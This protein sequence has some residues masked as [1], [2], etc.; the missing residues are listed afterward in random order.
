MIWIDARLRS[1]MSDDASRNGKSK[2]KTIYPKGINEV[3]TMISQL[4]PIDMMQ[5]EYDV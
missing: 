4:P 2:L 1:T 3:D 5:E